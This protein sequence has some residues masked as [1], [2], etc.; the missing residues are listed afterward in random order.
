M[1]NPFEFLTAWVR[2]NVNVTCYDDEAGAKGHAN[3]YLSEGAVAGFS[4]TSLIR[5]AGGNVVN[6]MRNALDSAADREVDRLS[7]KD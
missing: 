2:E 4:P 1:A 3:S 7:S 6:F 5:A